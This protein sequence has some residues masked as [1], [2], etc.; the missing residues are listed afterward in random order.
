MWYFIVSAAARNF[1]RI[2]PWELF[3]SPPRDEAGLLRSFFL[4]ELFVDEQRG[5]NIVILLADDKFL[6]STMECAKRKEKIL[7]SPIIRVYGCIW[8]VQGMGKFSWFLFSKFRWSSLPTLLLVTFPPSKVR[9]IEIRI[10]LQILNKQSKYI[11][12]STILSVAGARILVLL[13]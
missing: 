6:W 2:S 10:K 8:Y 9:T 1:F 5:R 7:W 13:A 3:V 11:I 4:S 12:K